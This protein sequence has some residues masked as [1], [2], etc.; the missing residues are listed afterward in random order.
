MG[1]RAE[2]LRKGGLVA[3]CGFACAGGRPCLCPDSVRSHLPTY[4]SLLLEQ[5]K[6]DIRA[7]LA[8]ARLRG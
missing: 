1:A 6:V 8:E 7:K 4:R 3:L 2:G 5:V